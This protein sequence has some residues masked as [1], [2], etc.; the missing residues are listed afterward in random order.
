MKS[1][2]QLSI[3]AALLASCAVVGASDAI[4]R[5]PRELQQARACHD[6]VCEI[7]V[8]VKGCDVTVDPYF[9]VMVPQPDKENP[10]AFHPITLKWTI[11]DGTF[12]ADS[13]RWKDP[14]AIRVFTAPKLAPDK[15]T[16]S[17]RNSGIR[18]VYHYGVRVIGASGQ[19]CAELDPTGIN[20]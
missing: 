6:T 10:G 11:K 7:A 19:L 4:Q 8:T 5:Q 1:R 16:I 13:I 20:D 3:V 17:F 15:K 9:M 2:T 12:A 18:G 14:G